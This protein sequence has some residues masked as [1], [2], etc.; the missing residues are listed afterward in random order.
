MKLNQ[1]MHYIV[2]AISRCLGKNNNG[3]FKIIMDSLFNNGCFS[4]YSSAFTF[5]S[6]YSNAFTSKFIKKQINQ[7]VFLLARNHGVSVYRYSLLK[8]KH[9]ETN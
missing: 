6:Q 5:A 4:Q 3:R 1:K 9:L 7:S 2:K 8:D